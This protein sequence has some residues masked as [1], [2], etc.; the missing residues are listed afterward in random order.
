MWFEIATRV[1]SILNIIDKM[2]KDMLD[3][4][5]VVSI[6]KILIDSQTKE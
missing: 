3:F 1:A 2:F 6:H 4:G 5:I